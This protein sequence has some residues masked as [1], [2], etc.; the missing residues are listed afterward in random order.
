MNKEELELF[1]KFNNK[2]LRDNLTKDY[3]SNKSEESLE[4]NYKRLI[5]R[6]KELVGDKYA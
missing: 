4:Y 6:I 5:Q 1:K 3:Y 2:L